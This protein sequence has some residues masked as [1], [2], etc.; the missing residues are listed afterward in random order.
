MDDVVQLGRSLERD[1]YA[2]P[3]IDSTTLRHHADIK[4]LRK[5]MELKIARG[6]KADDHEE[7]Q[8]HTWQ[9]TM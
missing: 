2:D 1:Q 9:Q 6:H 8:T 5:E 3:V 7:E 4:T